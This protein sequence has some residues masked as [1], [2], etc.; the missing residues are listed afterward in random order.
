M[1]GSFKHMSQV[2]QIE[3]HDSSLSSLSYWPPRPP[4]APLVDIAQFLPNLTFDLF[5]QMPLLM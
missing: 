1:S 3:F 4:S 2:T 5:L